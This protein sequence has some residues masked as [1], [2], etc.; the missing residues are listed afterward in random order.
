[1]DEDVIEAARRNS[2]RNLHHAW[3]RLEEWDDDTM[4]P[5]CYVEEPVPSAEKDDPF[6]V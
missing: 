3:L 4:P 5:E 1:M 6:S 2:L